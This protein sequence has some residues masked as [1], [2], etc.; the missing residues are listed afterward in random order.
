MPIPKEIL[1]VKR[2]VNT[3]VIAY[4]K[5]KRLFAVRQ[6]VGCRNDNGRHLPANGPTIGHIEDGRYVPLAAGSPARVAASSIDLKG[7]AGAV[8]CDRVFKDIQ[9]ELL[10][11]F[12]PADML[13]AYCISVLRVMEPGIKDNELKETFE[14]SFLSEFYPQAALS[15]N[16]V[17][18]FLNDLGKAYSK[19]A[20]FMRGRAAAVG[21]DHHLLIDGTLKPNESR[22]NTLSDF[23]RKS[24]TQGGRDLS[25]LYA[26]DLEAM[27][28]ICSQCFPG[29]MLDATA[30]EQFIAECGVK[31]GMIVADKGFPA[32]AAA[33]HFKSNPEL[34]YLNP[35][36]RNARFIESHALLDFTGILPGYDHVTF[37][38]EKCIGCDKWLYSFRD[39][40]R[41]A[42]EERDWLARA[43]KGGTYSF[44]ALRAKQRVFGTIVLECD[45]DLLPETAYKAYSDRWE[46]EVVMRYYKSA[47]EFD[48][49]RVQD[50]YSVIGSEFCDFLSTLLTFRLI[51]AFD[52]ADLLEKRTYKKVMSVLDRA[53]KV[54]LSA[55]DNWQLVKLNASHEDMLVALGLLPRPETSPKR[56]PSRPKKTAV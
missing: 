49:T 6:R 52:K 17:C 50:D 53:K 51:K 11:V 1:S 28:P 5:D 47:C 13:K 37:R 2:P 33:A 14:T 12:A 9:G 10:A 30:Y 35:I 16:T 26:F 54:R 23:S 44:E 27:E 19:I 55:S 25:V 42:Q 43:K 29:N 20:S 45:L 40:A 32:S 38:K 56:R 39:A 15:K 4:G 31:R 22:A 8:L 21:L 46:I 18:K 24:K 34:H 36:K 3:V 7:W 41:A 48:E